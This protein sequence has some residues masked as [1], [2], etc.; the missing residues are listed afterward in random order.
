MP[1]VEKRT[2]A[3]ALLA[4]AAAILAFAAVG[5]RSH[6]EGVTVAGVLATAWP[7]LSGTA[8]GWVIVRGWRKPTSLRPT[9]LV[10]WLSTLVV[11]MVLRKLVSATVVPSF[12][13]VA[14]CA[15]AILVLGWRGVVAVLARR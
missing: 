15:T 2:V 7:F 4:D 14:A 9:G 13:V 1:S 6:A 8:V 10:V 11:G 5:R 3:L 12:V